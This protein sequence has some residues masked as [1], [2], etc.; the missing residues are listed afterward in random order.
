MVEPIT[1]RRAV[2]LTAGAGLAGAAGLAGCSVPVVPQRFPNLTYAHL[3]PIVLDVGDLAVD[4]AYEPPF[5]HPNVEHEMPVPPERAVRQ[6]A[7]DRLRAGGRLRRGVTVIKQAS[8]VEEP[9]DRT[10]GVAGLLTTDQ[11]RRY[12]AVLEVEVRVESPGLEGGFAQ[13][14]I[15]RTQTA[16][17]DQTL[18]ERD[19]LL[20]ELTEALMTDLNRELEKS[21]RAHLAPFLL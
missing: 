20:F 1:R 11:A 7:A 2:V 8:V 19:L 6:W 16:P 17:E 4:T 9:L 14:R 5:R 12:V 18:N 10:A 3:D 21:I 15:E 13:A